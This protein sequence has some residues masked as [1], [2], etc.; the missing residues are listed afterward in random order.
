MIVDDF[1]GSNLV[2]L[3]QPYQPFLVVLTVSIFRNVWNSWLIN[4]FSWNSWLINWFSRESMDPLLKVKGCLSTTDQSQPVVAYHCLLENQRQHFW[5]PIS[6]IMATGDTLVLWPPW[7][8]VAHKNRHNHDIPW[9]TISTT[10]SK[11]KCPCWTTS[12]TI[13]NHIANHE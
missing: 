1:L 6:W 2:L 4:R 5:C 12:I 9:W 11:H 3:Y 13:V 7:K 8:Q 10:L